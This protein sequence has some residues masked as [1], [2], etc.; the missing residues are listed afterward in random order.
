[1]MDKRLMSGIRFVIDE[2]GR[3]VA[4]QIDL[5]KR[6]AIWEDFWNGLVSESRGRAFLMSSIGLAAVCAEYRP[7]VDR[8]VDAARVEACDTGER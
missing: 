5:R 1:M 8:T 4:V 3:K 2:K 6:G 7:N